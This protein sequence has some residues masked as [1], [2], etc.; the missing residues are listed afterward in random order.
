M[1][2]LPPVA[3]KLGAIFSSLGLGLATLSLGLKPLPAPRGRARGPHWLAAS[4]SKRAGEVLALQLSPLWIASV[5][6][7]NQQRVSPFTT[8]E[9]TPAAGV[10]V[11]GGFYT[12]WGPWGYMLYCTACAA[13]YLAV[14]LLSPAAC[15]QA[16]PTGPCWLRTLSRAQGVP[17]HSRYVV[18]ANLWIA[19]FSF[20][21]N[22]W[23]VSSLAA[24]QE[25]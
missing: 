21:G 11:A 19:I 9:L 12:R 14:P 10:V 13:P 16:R 20:I 18:K 4:P 17:W 2:S 25:R 15:D 1:D 7:H 8:R 24:Q 3:V 23:R 6:E 22:Y 5:G